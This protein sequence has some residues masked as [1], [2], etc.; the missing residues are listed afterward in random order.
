MSYAKAGAS[1]IV[2]LARSDLSEL[3]D[4]I[5]A[6][7]KRAGR[8]PPKVFRAHVDIT[9][10]AALEKIVNEVLSIF[11]HVDTLI[12]NAGYLE[13]FAPLAN[14]DPEEWWKTFEVNV[15][16]RVSYHTFIPAFTTKEPAQDHSNLFEC[17]GKSQYPRLVIIRHHK[18]GSA[19]VEWF[20]DGRI[21]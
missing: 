20:P 7:A 12:N 4:E 1:G 18:I 6:A 19:A 13:R 14:S 8:N 2:V 21:W 9:D 16:G 10:Q 15:K 11:G 3:E 5:V 17:G